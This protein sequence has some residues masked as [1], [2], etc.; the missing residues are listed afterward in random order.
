MGAEKDTANTILIVEDESQVLEMVSGILSRSGYQVL[1]A[2]SGDEALQIGR[3]FSGHI[4]LVL[5]DIVMPGMS[6]GEVVR[7]LQQIKPKIQALYMS[8]YTKYTMVGQGSLESVK[9]FIWKPFSP[10]EL[11][12]KVREV[13]GDPAETH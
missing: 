9:S 3:N 13:L 10:D 5:T 8:G 11:L 1:S 7:Q 12:G 6:G 2:R 4:D